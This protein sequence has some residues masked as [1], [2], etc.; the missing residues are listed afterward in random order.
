MPTNL[1]LYTLDFMSHNNC[2]IKIIY[3]LNSNIL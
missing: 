3:K 1:E 2:C